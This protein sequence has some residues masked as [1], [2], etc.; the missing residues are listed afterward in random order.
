MSAEGEI[1]KDD[2]RLNVEKNS[3]NVFIFYNISTHSLQIESHV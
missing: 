2:I 1:Y 3:K